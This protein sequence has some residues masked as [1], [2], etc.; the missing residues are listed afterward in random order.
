M[1]DD[2]DNAQAQAA[3]GNAQQQQQLFFNTL[4]N[5]LNDRTPQLKSIPCGVFKTG[6]DFDQ[7]L[8]VFRDN[9]K[10]VNRLT[11]ADEDRIN[12]LCKVWIPT[13]LEVGSTRSVYDNLDTTVKADW[14]MLKDALSKSFRDDTEMIAFLNNEGAYRRLPGVSLRDFKNGLI[15]RMEKYMSGLKDVPQEWERTAVRRFRAGLDNPILAAHILMSCTGTKHNL[16]SAFDVAV[17]YENT[18]S[19]LN[20]SDGA[21]A[22]DPTMASML[23]IPAFSA[24]SLEPPQFSVLSSH[25]EK[26]VEALETG[27]KKQEMDITEIKANV[28]DVKEN[29]KEIKQEIT[30]PK[31]FQRQFFRPQTRPPYPAPRAPMQSSSFR[32]YYPNL[33]RFAGSRPQYMP[34]LSGGPGY[35]THQPALA[36]QR[37]LFKPNGQTDKPA[38]EQKQEAQGASGTV[39]GA[40]EARDDG[41]IDQISF[42]NPNLQAGSYDFG[43]GWVGDEGSEAASLGYEP[44]PDGVFVYSEVPF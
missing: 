40:V 8:S 44:Q 27:Q 16:E 2:Q 7:W 36:G 21:K 6:Q 38:L 28:M 37:A 24:L 42:P 26:R 13:K 31:V 19:T 32:S 34:G 39:V 25:Q 10:A 5:R 23:P 12:D 41:N 35:V 43:Q 20:Q 33:N 9:V 4:I 11:D 30:R 18:I 1:P 22:A 29:I 3:Q 14:A 15:M 17:N